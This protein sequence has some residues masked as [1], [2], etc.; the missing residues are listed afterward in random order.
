MAD[1][2]RLGLGAALPKDGDVKRQEL[3]TNDKLRKQLLGKDHAKKQNKE[4]MKAHRP[5]QMN[6]SKPRPISTKLEPPVYD[7]DDEGGRSSLFKSKRKRS[8]GNEDPTKDTTSIQKQS[9]PRG[10]PEDALAVWSLNKGK[11]NYLDEVL[12]EK[13]R[14]KQ[15]KK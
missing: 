6:T 10:D 9:S 8:Q 11:G 3:S 15:K 1:Q 7:S 14:K 13:S 4:A 2:A 12:A 5:G